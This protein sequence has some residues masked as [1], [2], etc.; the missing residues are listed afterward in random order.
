M[1]VVCVGVTGGG[2]HSSDGCAFTSTLYKYDFRKGDL[3]VLSLERVRRV[4]RVSISSEMV[5]CGRGVRSEC[6]GVCGNVCCV[7]PVVRDSVVCLCK[8]C[9]GRCAF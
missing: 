2:G 4:R 6:M 1:C 8:E 3:F 5:M 9:D 7:A